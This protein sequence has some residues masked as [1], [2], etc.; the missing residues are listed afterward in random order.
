MT[1]TTLISNKILCSLPISQH[2]Y[3]IHQNKNLLNVHWKTLQMAH[4]TVKVIIKSNIKAP[5]KLYQLS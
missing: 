5:A 2:Q 3:H 4:F 1:I